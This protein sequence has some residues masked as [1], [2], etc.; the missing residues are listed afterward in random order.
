MVLCDLAYI[1]ID[2]P[3]MPYIIHYEI[4]ILGLYILVMIHHSLPLLI[5]PKRT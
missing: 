3:D 5:Y 1:K 2:I 4:T